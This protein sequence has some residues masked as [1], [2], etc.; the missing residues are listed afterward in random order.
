LAGIVSALGYL[1]TACSSATQAVALL[2]DAEREGQPFALAV[3]AM[4]Y[5][6]GSSGLD[7]KATLRDLGLKAPVIVSADSEVRGHEHFGITA[8]IRRPYDRKMVEQAL[9][10]SLAHAS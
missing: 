1:P 4:I 8:V 6:D 2:A 7:K 9:H 5:S 3:V 10:D